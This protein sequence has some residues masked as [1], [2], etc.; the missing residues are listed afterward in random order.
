MIHICKAL[1][2]LQRKCREIGGYLAKIDDS[3]ENNWIYQQVKKSSIIKSNISCLQKG[4]YL[5]CITSVQININ[6]GISYNLNLQRNNFEKK[7]SEQKLMSSRFK[8]KQTSID[9]CILLETV[10]VSLY[11]YYFFAAVSSAAM[12]PYLLLCLPL[13]LNKKY[14]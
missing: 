1:L 5:L 7:H 6:A 9:T 13:T 3:S 10:S 2:T 4:L 11:A 8:T 14:V 12:L